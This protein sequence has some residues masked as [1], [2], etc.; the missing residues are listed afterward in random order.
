MRDICVN[1]ANILCFLFLQTGYR[2]RLSQQ[3]L[4]DCSWGFGNDACNGGEEYRAYQWVIKHGGIPSEFVYG[5]YL[6]MVSI[7]VNYFIQL[8][9]TGK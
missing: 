9:K 1:Y 7:D 3:A 5:P 4:V 6:G 2:V 8:V